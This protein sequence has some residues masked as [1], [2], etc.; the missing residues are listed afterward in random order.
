[1]STDVR[2]FADSFTDSAPAAKRRQTPYK[3]RLATSI[4]VVMEE[5]VKEAVA[6]QEIM[7]KV[8]AWLETQRTLSNDLMHDISQLAPLDHRMQMLLRRNNDLLLRVGEL[9]HYLLDLALLI[10]QMERRLNTAVTN[11]RRAV[12]PPPAAPGERNGNGT[13]GA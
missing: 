11:S 3:P 9:D 7:K 5:S 13:G 1:M 2:I 10:P 6:A 12:D 8:S 4:K